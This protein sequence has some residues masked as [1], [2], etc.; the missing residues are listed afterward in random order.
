M[1]YYSRVVIHTAPKLIKAS[2]PITMAILLSCIISS[3]L[4]LAVPEKIWATNCTKIKIAPGSSNA[5]DSIKGK[6]VDS[7]TH[8]P[9]PFATIAFYEKD[10][11]SMTIMSNGKG[12]FSTFLKEKSPKV[13]LSAIGYQERICYLGNKFSN[14]LSLVPADNI[15]PGIIVS[16]KIKKKPR[17]R[18]LIKNV[19]KYFEQNYGEFSFGQ[20]YKVYSSTRN[21]DTQKGSWID[22]VNVH[23]DKHLGLIQIKKWQR[24]TMSFDRKFSNFIGLP[25]FVLGD[26]LPCADI[27]RMGF[28]IDKNQSPN[29]DFRLQASYIDKDYGAVNLVS[30]K[31]VRNFSN[32][33]I[34]G[35]SFLKLPFGYV[36]GEMIVRKDDFAVVNVKYICEAETAILNKGIKDAYNSLYW[37]ADR[38]GKIMSNF[39]VYKYEYVYQKDTIAGKYFVQT[40]KANGYDTGYQIET[41]QK[42]Q[43][44]YRFDANSTGI[45]IL[46]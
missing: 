39:V 11:I 4:F 25:K 8:L 32:P 33:P 36:K 13:V 19:M 30:F 44:G 22:L 35:R 15:L 37:K 1:F 42:V 10:S 23:F 34:A 14:L 5:S 43:L 40:I 17:C 46:E 9:I 28:I 45:K 6:I 31:L 27:L 18:R 16:G 3:C 2:Y 26:I 20:T 41:N 24:D 12:E 7:I 21:Y 38:L 29:F